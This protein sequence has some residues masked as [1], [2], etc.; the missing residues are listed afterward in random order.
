MGYHKKWRD[1]GWLIYII[2]RHVDTF[3]MMYDAHLL[4]Y[5]MLHTTFTTH[6]ADGNE[7][8]IH[9]AHDRFESKHDVLYQS[10]SYGTISTLAMGAG[11]LDDGHGDC[12]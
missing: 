3:Y 2:I 8:S 6:L 10:P 7:H 4:M 9:G 5:G 12:N 1:P 11:G